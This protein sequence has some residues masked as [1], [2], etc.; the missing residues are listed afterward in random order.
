MFWG[1]VPS[2]QILHVGGAGCGVQVVAPQ[3][4]ALGLS[5]PPRPPLWAALSGVCGE[6]VSQPLSLFKC[7]PSFARLL[8]RNLGVT[9]QFLGFC[10]FCFAEEVVSCV[11]VGCLD[12][13]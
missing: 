8:R 10:L 5:A 13:V 12:L 4:A 1:L 6:T 2:V 3:G 9:G 11:P 7:G